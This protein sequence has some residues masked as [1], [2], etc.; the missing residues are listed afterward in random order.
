V[1]C[2]VGLVVDDHVTS[3]HDD[4]ARST[5][6]SAVVAG[7]AGLPNPRGR[8][9]LEANTEDRPTLCGGSGR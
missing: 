4:V 5:L 7:I 2:Y 1:R 8:R 6:T 3:S 9:V